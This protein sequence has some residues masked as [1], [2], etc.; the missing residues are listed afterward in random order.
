[1]T[2]HDSSRPT[3]LQKSH[4]VRRYLR[5]CQTGGLLFATASLLPIAALWMPTLFQSAAR[6]L[7]AEVDLQT[8]TMWNAYAVATGLAG[9]YSV[10]IG[11]SFERLLVKIFGDA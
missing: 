5:V 3:G 10:V 1:M 6:A 4:P 9:I 11:W 2:H 7:G 8:I